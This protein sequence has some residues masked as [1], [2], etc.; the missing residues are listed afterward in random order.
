MVRSI[1]GGNE[2]AK[3][4]VLESIGDVG[5]GISSGH[6][7]SDSQTILWR[8]T[9]DDEKRW[10]PSEAIQNSLE[11]AHVSDERMRFSGGFVSQQ[12]LSS[13]PTKATSSPGS[14]SLH[15]RDCCGQH[16]PSETTE[17]PY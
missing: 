5:Q 13:S 4:H 10:P 16:V 8:A 11:G 3:V 17:F 1:D 6:F 2:A 12:R 15:K 7:S 14:T 9:K